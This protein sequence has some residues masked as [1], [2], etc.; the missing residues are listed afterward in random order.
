MVAQS[1][2]AL[3]AGGLWRARKHCQVESTALWP[4]SAPQS[5]DCYGSGFSSCLPGTCWGTEQALRQ[6]EFP[7]QVVCSMWYVVA[8][9]G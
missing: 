2:S 3:L 7:G 5:E 1:P 8:V 6:E 4:H 9:V